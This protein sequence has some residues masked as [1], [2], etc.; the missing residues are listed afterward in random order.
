MYVVVFSLLT[1]A[2]QGLTQASRTYLALMTPEDERPLYL[3]INNALLGVLAVFVSGLIG[4]VAHSTHIY[5]ALC[6][7]IA[8]AV[9]ASYSARSLAPVSLEEKE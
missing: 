2:S 7:L 3:A 9:F 8:M 5:G 6:L 4:V 1:L